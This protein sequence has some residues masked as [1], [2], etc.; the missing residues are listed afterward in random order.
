M[1]FACVYFYLLF[2]NFSGDNKI[3]FALN[4][5]VFFAVRSRAK[6]KEGTEGVAEASVLSCNSSNRGVSNPRFHPLGSL[7]HRALR[8]T[9]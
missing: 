7:H 8:A 5:G 6:K 4:A 9:P 3:N 1:S 2:S